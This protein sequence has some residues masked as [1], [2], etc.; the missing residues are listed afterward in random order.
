[1]ITLNIFA[2][3]LL[4]SI[5]I[6]EVGSVHC[7]ACNTRDNEECDNLDDSGNSTLTTTCEDTCAT[8]KGQWGNINAYERRFL[9]WRGCGPIAECTQA[10][11]MCCHCKDDYC[12]FGNVCFSHSIIPISNIVLNYLYPPSEENSLNPL[13][14][15]KKSYAP[16]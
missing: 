4:V 13:Q 12:N 8:V 11:A 6:K 2:L 9:L 14:H 7:Y 15:W 5:F 3:F 10:Q 16:I 1:M